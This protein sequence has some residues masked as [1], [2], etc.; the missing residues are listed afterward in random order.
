MAGYSLFSKAGVITALIVVAVFSASSP[1]LA[2]KDS[3]KD[4]PQTLKLEVID[5]Y[6]EI[7]TGPGR[8]YPVFHVIEQGE[9]IEVLTRRPGWYEVRSKNGRVGWTRSREVSR[10][11]QPSGEPA[12]LPSVS[13]GDYLKNSWRIGFLAGPFSGGELQ[14]VDSFSLNVGYRPWSWLGFD[15]EAGNLYGTGVKGSYKGGNFL[16]EPFSRWRYSPVFLLGKGSMKTGPKD[17]STEGTSEDSDFETYGFGINSYVG[18]NFV[19]RTEYRIY[20]VVINE[21]E[22]RLDAWRIGFNTFF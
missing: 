18:R 7:R 15:L 19:V 14:G 22:E 11:L 12:D 16:I 10:T 8:G 20:D 13:Y 5:P 17:S 2:K 6:V 9:R 21:N 4:I 1:A 3:V